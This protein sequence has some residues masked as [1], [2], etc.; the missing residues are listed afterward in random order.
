MINRIFKKNL[1]LIIKTCINI[2]YKYNF[3][4]FIPIYRI[5]SLD[6]TNQM[7]EFLRKN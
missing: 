1:L 5:S 7:F 2:F 6:C 4:I 3:K